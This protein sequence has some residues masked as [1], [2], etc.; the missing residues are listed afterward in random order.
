MA[1]GPL[2]TEYLLSEPGSAADVAAVSIVEHIIATAR[3][4]ALCWPQLPSDLDTF[5]AGALAW[6]NKVRRFRSGPFDQFGFRP[7]SILIAG[8][9]D[10]DP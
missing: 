3:E 4:V 10:L 2:G 5:A 8:A 9:P 7:D 6:I 1:L